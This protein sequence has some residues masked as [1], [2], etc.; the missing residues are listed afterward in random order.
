MTASA[1]PRHRRAGRDKPKPTLVYQMCT[2]Q[3]VDA[4]TLEGE[5]TYDF[6]AEQVFE[7]ECECG[8]THTSTLF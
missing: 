4:S 2:G 1:H 5:Y 6:L 7:W 8:E 3:L